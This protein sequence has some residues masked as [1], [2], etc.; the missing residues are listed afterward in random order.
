M[1]TLLIVGAGLEAV[2]GIELAKSMG[3]HTVVSDINPNAPGQS[4]G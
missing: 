2:P 4:R 3:L 1:K